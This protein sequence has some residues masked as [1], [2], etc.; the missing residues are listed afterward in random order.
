M[1]LIRG[2]LLIA[3]PAVA[4]GA[5]TNGPPPSPQRAETLTVSVPSAATANPV[6]FYLERTAGNVAVVSPE[7]PLPLPSGAVRGL[8]Q[9]RGPKVRLLI[10]P[11]VVGLRLRSVA[12]GEDLRVEHQGRDSSGPVVFTAEGPS[13]TLV[14][15]GGELGLRVF[16]DRM[17]TRRAP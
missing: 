5:Q 2:L 11:G 14:R 4:A 13:I 1:R 3:L 8:L 12:P 9:G 7:A 6:R 17:Q 10:E 16:A 15:S